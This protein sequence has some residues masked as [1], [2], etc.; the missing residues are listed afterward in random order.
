MARVSAYQCRTRYPRNVMTSAIKP[1]I[2][3][4]SVA[5]RCV[6]TDASV[7]APMIVLRIRK[8]TMVKTL[9]ND[10]MIAP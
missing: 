2:T 3:M 6:E 7:C 10:G 1:M 9:N 4:P 5:L 8:D